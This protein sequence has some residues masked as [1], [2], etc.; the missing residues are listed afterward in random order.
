MVRLRGAARRRGERSAA[1]VPCDRAVRV[2]ACLESCSGQLPDSY[3]NTDTG[4]S[5]AVCDECLSRLLLLLFPVLLCSSST[6]TAH[7][8]D[9]ILSLYNT[10]LPVTV[11]YRLNNKLFCATKN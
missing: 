3:G 6:E 1:E 11:E 5:A 2:T 9:G 7:S 8:Q 4:E 10:Y